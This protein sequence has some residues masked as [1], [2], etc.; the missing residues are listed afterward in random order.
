M[1]KFD[2]DCLEKGRIDTW[3]KVR[4]WKKLM[5]KDMKRR[6]QKELSKQGDEQNK[7]IL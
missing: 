5:S 1:L 6:R 4:E 3:K 7:F 2:I